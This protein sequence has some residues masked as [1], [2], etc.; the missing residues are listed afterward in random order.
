MVSCVRP[1]IYIYIYQYRNYSTLLAIWD[2]RGQLG[3]QLARLGRPA[4]LDV[5]ATGS[6]WLLCALLGDLLGQF[7]ALLDRFGYSK[8]VALCSETSISLRRGSVSSMLAWLP[9]FGCSARFCAPW[10]P[11]FGCPACSWAPWL[12]RFACPVR[13]WVHWLGQFGYPVRS[14]V[15]WVSRFGC[16]VRSWAPWLV[17]FGPGWLDL[18]ALRA[19]GHPGWLDFGAIAPRLA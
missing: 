12:H 18:A 19:P 7:G 13:S 2:S 8:S 6:I 9:Q 10:L 15:L 1:Y 4:W 3:D 5:P 14:C 16:S 11:R 17:Q